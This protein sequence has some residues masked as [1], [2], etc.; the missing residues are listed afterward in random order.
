[1]NACD[2]SNNI[3]GFSC[4]ESLVCHARAVNILFLKE[5]SSRLV[6]NEF[7]NLFLFLETC[8]KKILVRMTQLF[9]FLAATLF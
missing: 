1:M 2:E 3:H 6:Y 8:L 4:F 9:V 5:D 7:L